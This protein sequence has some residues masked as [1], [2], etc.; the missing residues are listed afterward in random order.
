MV[1]GEEKPPSR[2]QREIRN[3]FRESH[4][5]VRDVK[6][7]EEVICCRQLSTPEVPTCRISL[8]RVPKPMN[9]P[10]PAPAEAHFQMARSRERLDA[11]ACACF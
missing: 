9:W 10:I 11:K 4:I 6:R 3:D 5:E 1:R 7:L 2:R 8:R